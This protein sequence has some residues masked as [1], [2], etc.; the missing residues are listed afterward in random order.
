MTVTPKDR[1]KKGCIKKDHLGS[2]RAIMPLFVTLCVL[3]LLLPL[4]KTCSCT[5]HIGPVCR[6]RSLR[7]ILFDESFR[8]RK[9]RSLF[10]PTKRWYDFKHQELD[11]WWD[12]MLIV[13]L[14]ENCCSM[15]LGWF[16]M[17]DDRFLTSPPFD[18]YE[19]SKKTSSKRWPQKQWHLNWNLQ[20]NHRVNQGT[21]MAT[22]QYQQ[23]SYLLTWMLIGANQLKGFGVCKR[24]S[25]CESSW[26][27]RRP[28]VEGIRFYPHLKLTASLPLK[29]DGWNTRFLFG[30]G[31]TVT[32]RE[33]RNLVDGC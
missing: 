16:R 32:F 23:A 33:C 17:K 27:W 22:N 21:K 14:I 25:C 1:V 8:K 18:S 7:F 15:H 11:L 30:M 24:W 3:L 5:Y 31:Q 10:Y 12:G 6:N 28:R 4:S 20:K 2:R 9:R 19:S 29:M 26:D 13:I